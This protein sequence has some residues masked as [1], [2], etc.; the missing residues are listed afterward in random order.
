MCAGKVATP[1]TSLEYL[2][3]DLAAEWHHAL[4]G[5]LKPSH[6]VPGSGKRVWWRCHVDPSHEWQTTIRK[7]VEGTGCP[8]C[9]GKC[10]TATNSLAR[11]APDVAAQWHRTENGELK[12][13]DVVPGSHTKV[14]WQ[15]PADA[16]HEWR[17]VVKNRVAGIGCPF[18]AGR[19]VNSS[20]SLRGL[21][22]DIA[23]KWHPTKNVPLTPDNLT[24][25]SGVRVWWQCALDGSHEWEASI[26]NRS[27]G[28]GCPM[29]GGQIATS[30]T[31]LRTLHP[32]LAKEWHPLKNHDLTPDDVTPGSG[33]KVWWRCSADASHEWQTSIG[34]RA[35]N[36]R[37]C[38]MCA[39]KIAT[40]KTS[41][42]ALYPAVAN[43]W[44]PTKNGELTPDRVMPC[45]NK[46]VWWKCCHNPSHVWKAVIQSRTDGCGCPMCR[47]VPRSR[48]EIILACELVAFLEFDLDNHGVVVADRVL[49]VDIILPCLQLIVEYDGSYWH[50]GKDSADER[51][52]NRLRK[53][54]WR[55]NPGS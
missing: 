38:P 42:R 12:P 36:D 5:D 47:L 54:G 30:A 23:S 50:Q 11:V 9:A 22:P 31:S 40:A 55:S 3:P 26:H 2:H 14:W 16:S 48:D 13:C 45:S 41:L 19:A 53:A 18:C 24:V 44:H 49:D 7:R 39:G 1:V 34:H 52:S 6:V 4:N 51:K 29:C 35:R 33:V 20:N 25:G 21:R 46:K 43:E 32:E 37:G 17:A 28:N 8:M 27:K 10:A 15:C